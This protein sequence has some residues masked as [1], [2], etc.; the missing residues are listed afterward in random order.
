MHLA[1]RAS[2]GAWQGSALQMQQELETKR[3][4]WLT[5]ALLHSY[6]SIHHAQPRLKLQMERA[7]WA[8]RPRDMPPAIISGD[9]RRPPS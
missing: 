9:R 4:V 5:A 3:L 2:Q 7:R 6:I 1:A 8:D